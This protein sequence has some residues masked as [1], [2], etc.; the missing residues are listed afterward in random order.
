M[1]KALAS[2]GLF[3]V[4]ATEAVPA[5]AATGSYSATVNALYVPI[6]SATPPQVTLNSGSGTVGSCR[7]PPAVQRIFKLPATAQGEKMRLLLV[8][9]Q[10]SGRSVIVYWDDAQKDADGY[11]IAQL[12]GMF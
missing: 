1:K 3:C 9:A 10:V 4:L 6:S 2:L 12:V 7:M 8:E 11:C 5:F